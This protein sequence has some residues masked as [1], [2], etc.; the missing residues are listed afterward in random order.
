M[1][2]A[3][4]DKSAQVDDDEPTRAAAGLMMKGR[5]DVGVA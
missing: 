2:G 3:A 5:I 1:F 4:C